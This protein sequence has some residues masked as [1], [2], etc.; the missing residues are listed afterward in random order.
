VNRPARPIDPKRIE[1][2]DDATVAARNATTPTRR[3]ERG[4]RMG[5]FARSVLQA[6][7]RRAKPEWNA[8]MVAHEV[9][10]RFAGAE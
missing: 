3:V 6:G 8:L 7:I 5:A 9:K 10:R 1:V 2:I 4:L